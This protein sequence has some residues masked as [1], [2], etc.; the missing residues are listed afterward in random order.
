M[1]RI[2]SNKVV[3]PMTDVAFNFFVSPCPLQKEKPDF[4]GF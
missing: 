1:R 4:S 3:S 2:V